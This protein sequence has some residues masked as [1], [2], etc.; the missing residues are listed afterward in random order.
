MYVKRCSTNDDFIVA[1]LPT[2]ALRY[3]TQQHST[4]KFSLFCSIKFGLFFIE[5]IGLSITLDL[6]VSVSPYMFYKSHLLNT[7]TSVCNHLLICCPF[8]QSV[9]ACTNN[10]KIELIQWSE[11][12]VPIQ[13]NTNY[14]QSLFYVTYT[15]THKLTTNCG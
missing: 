15:L 8:Y 9:G 6:C 10:A 2:I 11:T 14:N 3:H 1:L 5:S 12:S 7:I 4:L 13:L